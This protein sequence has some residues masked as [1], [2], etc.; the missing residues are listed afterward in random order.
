M[1]ENGIK[2]W[3]IGM[4]TFFIIAY[5]VYADGLWG[6]WYFLMIVSS[7]GWVVAGVGA[8]WILVGF[9]SKE[10]ET[11]AQTQLK[12]LNRFCEQCGRPI[13]VGAKFCG[14]CGEPLMSND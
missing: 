14:S 5:I 4:I 2:V 1:T 6:D 9:F 7:F 8:I 12:S 13:S 3:I 11:Q 10:E